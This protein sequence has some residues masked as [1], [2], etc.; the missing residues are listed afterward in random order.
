M[1]VGEKS[2]CLLEVDTL[3]LFKDAFMENKRVYC[4]KKKK[5][6]NSFEDE[7][8]YKLSFFIVYN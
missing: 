1:L 2:D 6:F 5:R 3:L 8:Y 7:F 4:L